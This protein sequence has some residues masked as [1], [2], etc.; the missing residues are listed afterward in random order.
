MKKTLLALGLAVTFAVSAGGYTPSPVMPMEESSWHYGIGIGFTNFDSMLVNSGQSVIGRLSIAKDIKQYND[1]TFGVELGMQNGN[2]S[3]LQL[4]AT[5][6]RDLGNV[7]VQ[8]FI[9]PMA[10]LLITAA[11]PLNDKTSAFIKGGIAFR[12]MHFDRDSINSLRKVNPELQ[13]GLSMNV[14]NRT[15]LSLAYQGVFAGKVG[16]VTINPT[17]A[18]GAGT[19]NVKNIPSQHGVLLTLTMTA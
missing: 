6:Y 1:F 5:Q 18:V 11:K 16:M 8:T 10:D 17:L 14:S 15:S 2:Q 4:N 9:K 3:R 12:Q 19:G 13:V 7:A